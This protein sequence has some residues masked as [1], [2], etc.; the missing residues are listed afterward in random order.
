MAWELTLYTLLGVAGG[1]ISALVAVLAWRHRARREALPFVA[2]MLAL[3][4]WA[5]VSGVQ[6]SLTTR[7]AQVG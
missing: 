3:G 6:L 1:G 2:L 5:L 7:A 4:S